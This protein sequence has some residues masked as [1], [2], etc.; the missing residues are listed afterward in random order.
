LKKLETLSTIEGRKVLI[1][2]FREL[3]YE[4][5][6]SSFMTLL[7]TW[8]IC[9]K[10]KEL[11]RFMKNEITVMHPLGLFKGTSLWMQ[12]I[13]NRFDFS[14]I[15]SFVYFGAAIL[16]TLI[17]VRRFNDNVT[18]TMVISGIAFEA[19]MLIFMFIVMLFTPNDD[20]TTAID[21]KEEDNEKELLIE[22]GEIGRDIAASVTK[23]EVLINSVDQLI[24]EQVNLINVVNQVARNSA[25]A[26]APNPQMLDTMRVTN[27]VLEEFKNTIESF[28]ESAKKLNN[29]EVES[30]VK[31]EVE[32]LL[33]NKINR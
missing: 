2:L 33:I 20:A 13:V 18:D 31:R 9:T 16:L 32:R 25:D 24:K 6:M 11:F 17:G 15:N 27:S 23:I 12:E 29:A 22:I 7:Q 30:A 19:L 26:V 8:R 14:T 3:R 4:K 28:N 5:Q 10:E 21:E 1:E